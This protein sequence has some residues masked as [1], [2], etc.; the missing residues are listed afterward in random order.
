MIPYL[1]SFYLFPYLF[2]VLFVILSRFDF[3]DH[4]YILFHPFRV[5]SFLMLS[6]NNGRV[7]LLS[8]SS[9]LVVRVIS[10]DAPNFIVER[11][12]VVFRLSESGVWKKGQDTLTDRED[13]DSYRKGLR[14]VSLG[15]R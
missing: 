3:F 4:L 13:F 8:R 1:F 5:F 15:Y 14:K 7:S 12:S 2:K 9:D 10:L 11:L 6:D